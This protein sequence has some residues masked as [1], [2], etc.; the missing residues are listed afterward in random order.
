MIQAPILRLPE[1]VAPTSHIIELGARDLDRTGSLLN[2]RPQPPVPADVDLREF[3]WMSLDIRR[4]RDSDLAAVATGEEFRAAVLLWCAAWHQV[5][6]A[7]L[8]DDDRLLANL[9]GFGRDVDAWKAVREGALRGFALCS[10]GRLYHPVVAEKAMAAFESLQ[11]NLRRTSHATEAR[12]RV[13]RNDARNEARDVNRDDARN[14]VQNR[15]RIEIDKEREKDA[16]PEARLPSD[17]EKDLF[18]RGKRV[19]GSNAGG[20]IK[21]LLASQDGSIPKTR[22]LIEVASTKQDPREY[23]GAVTSGKD[24]ERPPSPII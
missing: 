9:A 15:E 24:R 21:R 12:R 13:N 23:V 10:D 11:A 5:P 2:E 6:A 20:L 7:S 1:T 19:L 17:E 3:S 22:A 18:R 4:L 8:P 16:A 14:E